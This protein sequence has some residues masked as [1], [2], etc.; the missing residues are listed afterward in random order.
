MLS[1]SGNWSRLDITVLPVVVR[2]DTASKYACVNDIGW[3][4]SYDTSSSGIAAN[5]GS[6]THTIDTSITP[7]RGSSSR[8]YLRVENHS[9]AEI[10][11]VNRIEMT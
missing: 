8:W 6:T 4:I 10:S 5:S 3:L 9:T 2:P 1:D 11:S 7:W